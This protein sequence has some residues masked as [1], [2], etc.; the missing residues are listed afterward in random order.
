MLYGKVDP[1]YFEVSMQESVR[2]VF[3]TAQAQPA[4]CFLSQSGL[5]QN[6]SFWKWEFILFQH[7]FYA[8]LKVFK[9]IKK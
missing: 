2:G 5:L 3:E 6:V 9:T 4:W 1:E 7:D 8:K